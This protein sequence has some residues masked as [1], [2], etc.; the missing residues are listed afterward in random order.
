MNSQ[1]A[2]K[3]IY[4]QAKRLR[5][6]YKLPLDCNVYITWNGSVPTVLPFLEGS[7]GITNT[8]KLEKIL[9]KQCILI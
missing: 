6:A 4:K 8:I 3:E 5:V 1:Q 9:T 7:K 2:R